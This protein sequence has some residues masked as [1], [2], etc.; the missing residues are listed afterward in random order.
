M[1][2]IMLIAAM[3]AGFAVPA[4]GPTDHV[5][6]WG[7]RAERAPGWI[8]LGQGRYYEVQPGTEIPSWGRVK[9]V[10]EARLVIEQTRTPA[11]KRRLQQ[12]G[13]LVYDVLE[14]WIPREDLRLLR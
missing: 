7:R 12:Q 1:T 5:R 9:E 11:E 6:Y 8:E 10:G 3:A 14:L 2:S 4:G 13:A